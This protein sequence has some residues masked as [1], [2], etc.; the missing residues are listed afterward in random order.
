VGTAS[1]AAAIAAGIAANTLMKSGI[2]L[3]VGRGAF[4]RRTVAGLA[5]TCV[6]AL[7]AI[8]IHRL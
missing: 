7:P 1:A 3:V 6:T 5:I 8:A 2:A 4:R